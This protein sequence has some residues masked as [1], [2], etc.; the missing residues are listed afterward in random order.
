M[1]GAEPVLGGPEGDRSGK[2]RRTGGLFSKADEGAG[3][4][5]RGSP[6]WSMSPAASAW[7]SGS[8]ARGRSSERAACT[9][10][11]PVSAAK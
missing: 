2:E 1:G 3:V 4:I 8:E 10:D 11:A 7:I 9:T 6:G 5:D